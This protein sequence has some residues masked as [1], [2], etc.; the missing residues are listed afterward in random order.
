[1]KTFAHLHR[2]GSFLSKCVFLVS[3]YA[4]NYADISHTQNVTTKI[5]ERNH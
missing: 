2:E 5:N 4:R 3:K 1:M